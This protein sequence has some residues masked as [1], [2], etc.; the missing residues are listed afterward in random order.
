MHQIFTNVR[1]KRFIEV[2]GADRPPL[3]HEMAPVAFWTGILTVDSLRKEILD[4]INTWSYT[5]RIRF[6]KASLS[7]DDNV[8]TVKDKKYSYWNDRFGKLAI[9]GLKKRGLGEEVLFENFFDLVME[10]GPFSLQL[11]KL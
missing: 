6:N 4:E 1:I 10:K 5:D 8:L 11:Q 9:L 2:R 3:G 7:L